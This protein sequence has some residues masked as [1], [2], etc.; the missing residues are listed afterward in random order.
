MGT[1]LGLEL[2]KSQQLKFVSTEL[3]F[4]IIKSTWKLSYPSDIF[5]RGDTS[6]LVLMGI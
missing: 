5:T 4:I 1:W 3:S 2:L 6:V